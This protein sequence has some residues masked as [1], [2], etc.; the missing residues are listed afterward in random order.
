MKRR[1]WEVQRPWGSWAGGSESSPAWTNSC[2]RWL[3]DPS[4]CIN[5]PPRSP[6][7]WTLIGATVCPKVLPKAVS[8]NASSR[9]I[10][11]PLRHSALGMGGGPLQIASL[12]WEEP[13]PR[14]GKLELH[15][16]TAGDHRTSHR[17]PWKQIGIATSLHNTIAIAS[18]SH[19][20][21]A[22][23]RAHRANHICSFLPSLVF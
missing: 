10:S 9:S 8:G 20:G 14:L 13:R 1:G 23:G 16:R 3:G 6:A 18:S 12:A 11:R 22:L 17:Q 15:Q 19:P 7:N 5:G 21:P 2:R 4:S